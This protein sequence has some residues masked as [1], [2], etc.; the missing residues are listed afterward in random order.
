MDALRSYNAISSQVDA[1]KPWDGRVQST[2]VSL[3]QETRKGGEG[4]TL[5]YTGTTSRSEGDYRGQGVHE[6]FRS[7]Q[8][9]LSK[10][11]VHISRSTVDSTLQKGGETGRAS[12]ETFR[13]LDAKSG[14]TRE[15][16]HQTYNRLFSQMTAGKEQWFAQN[17]VQ[18]PQ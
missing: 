17:R 3:D 5:Q 4:S 16:D 13:M 8:E 14:Q 7:L 6:T 11:G 9:E 10:D 2:T 12:E 1:S 18:E 15:I